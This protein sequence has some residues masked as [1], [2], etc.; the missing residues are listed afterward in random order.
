MANDWL[1][2]RL[3]LP[4]PPYSTYMLFIF[5]IFPEF[6]KSKKTQ[7]QMKSML[8]LRDKL[9][10]NEIYLRLPAAVQLCSWWIFLF[11]LFPLSPPPLYQHW[12]NVKSKKH[13]FWFFERKQKNRLTK[14]ENAPHIFFFCCYA[15]HLSFDFHI[16]IFLSF[17]R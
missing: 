8:K 2:L 5:Y 13:L 12:K 9:H 6:A 17:F 7:K 15:R 14:T 10:E 3:S 1:P 4:R 16:W 11:S